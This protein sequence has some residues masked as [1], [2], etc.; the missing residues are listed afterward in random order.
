MAGVVVSPTMV[1]SRPRWTSRIP[2]M[3]ATRPERPT[4]YMK[5]RWAV[6]NGL[7]KLLGFLRGD[8]VQN[9]LKIL[10]NVLHRGDRGF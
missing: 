3:R 9:P 5:T 1:A 2:N 6:L 10:Q 4:P 7:E 8:C